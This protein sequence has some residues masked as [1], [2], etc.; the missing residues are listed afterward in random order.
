MISKLRGA[1]DELKPTEVIIDVSGVGYGLSIPLSTYEKIQQLKELSLYV[2]THH[3]EDQLRLFGF[4]TEVERNLFTILLDISGIGPSMALSILSGISIQLFVEAV[5]TEN[6]GL[7]MKIPGI[8]KAKADKLI[9]ELKR[10]LKKLRS[11]S[12]PVNERH[13]YKTDAVEALVSLGFDE[14][15]SA[16]AVDEAS[17]CSPDASIEQLIK[18]SL[19]LLS[20]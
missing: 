7:L 13:V 19:K 4:F 17:K 18:D 20:A 8:G 15:K 5:E 14:I 3:K 16:R 10:K 9:F 12:G 11:F 6:T 1:I 2:Y